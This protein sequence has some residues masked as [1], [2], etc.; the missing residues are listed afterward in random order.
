VILDNGRITSIVMLSGKAYRGKMFIDATYEGD[1]MAAAGV[2][3]T[4]GREANSQYG[5]TLNGV[6]TGLARGHQFDEPVDPYV[7]PGDP[8][9]GLLPGVTKGGP[10]DEGSGDRRIQAYCFRVCLTDAEDRLPFAKPAGYDP[11]RYELLLRTILAGASKHKWGYFT[12]VRMP[13]HKTDSN[14]AGP[15][16]TDNIGMNY[17]YPEGDYATRKRIIAEHETYQKGFMWFLANDPR[18]PQEIR[19]DMRSGDCRGMNSRTTGTGR[20]SSTFVRRGGWS[21]RT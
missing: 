20:T 5:E 21:G 14:N 9:S 7:R 13:N 10:G 3:Y 15:F 4:L 18:V 17:D 19:D 1:L 2:S 12:K 11:M 16:S 8:S 6:K